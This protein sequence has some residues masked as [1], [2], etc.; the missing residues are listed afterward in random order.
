MPVLRI[1]S[2]FRIRIR[3]HG[4]GFQ[5]LYPD[6]GDPKKTGYGSGS[7]LDMFLMLSKK[8]LLWHF[9]TKSKHVMTLKIKEKKI[10]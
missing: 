1:R 8:N 9:Y 3:I 5:N 7:Y 6:P 2:I 10:F 4:S